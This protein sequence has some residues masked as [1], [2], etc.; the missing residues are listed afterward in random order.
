[1]QFVLSD[2]DR[3]V[4]KGKHIIIL[5][6]SAAMNETNTG[7]ENYLCEGPDLHHSDKCSIRN[8][9]IAWVDHVLRI[10]WENA[11]VDNRK[12]TP[13]S[14]RVINVHPDATFR[15]KSRTLP[16]DCATIAFSEPA[17]DSLWTLLL[18]G[19]GA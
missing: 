3:L 2:L 16:P 15:A 4:R 9:Y 19:G 18:R 1:M 6:Q 8:S 13:V 11:T 10:N 5:C 17:D 14:G 7:G 12:I